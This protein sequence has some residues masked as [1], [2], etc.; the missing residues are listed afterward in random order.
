MSFATSASFCSDSS[1]TLR[2][3]SRNSSRCARDTSSFD[4]CTSFFRES[5]SRCLQGGQRKRALLSPGQP[6]R[7][8]LQGLRGVPMWGPPRS[9][10][11]RA[12]GL[13]MPPICLCG[14]PRPGARWATPSVAVFFARR[15]APSP[16]NGRSTSVA[17][18]PWPVERVS[19]G[20]PVRMPHVKGRPAHGSTATTPRHAP[21]PPGRGCGPGGLT[22]PRPARA[23]QPATSETELLRPST[24]LGSAADHGQH[25]THGPTTAVPPRR[26]GAACYSGGAMGPCCSGSTSRRHR[27]AVPPASAAQC[28]LHRHLFPRPLGPAAPDPPPGT[29]QRQTIGGLW[30]LRGRFGTAAVGGL[31][32]AVGQVTPT[33]APVPHAR[34]PSGGRA[35]PAFPLPFFCTA[36]EL[37]IH[38]APGSLGGPRV[39]D[40]PLG[41]EKG[42]LGAQP[43]RI[44][45]PQGCI[46]RGGAPPPP[47]Q[48]AQPMP[49]HCP[50]GAKCQPQWHL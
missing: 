34:A 49:S 5:A 42:V 21:R 26:R 43:L 27:G 13:R 17:C 20:F 11:G 48:G 9:L 24:G 50:P 44:P 19:T 10:V 4:L 35:A 3:R 12:G 33:Q 39:E 38:E 47:I 29:P 31:S 28:R 2:C 7:G 45:P 18:R 1:S 37:L 14:P 25:T 46:G 22:P 6:C 32:T 16:Q 15:C 36:T 8:A 30:D 40:D 41:S 23:R